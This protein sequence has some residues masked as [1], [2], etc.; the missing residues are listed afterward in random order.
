WIDAIPAPLEFAARYAYVKEP[1]KADR[2]LYNEREEFTLGANWFF[3]GHSNKLTF[4]FSHLTLDDTL[5]M[6]KE[7]ENRVRLQWDVSF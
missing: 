3:N 6:Q 4:D 7:S 5:L 1:N 2:M